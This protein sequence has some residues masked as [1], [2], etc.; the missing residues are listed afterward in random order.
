MAL[1]IQGG[2]YIGLAYGDV[3]FLDITS[4]ISQLSTLVR[5]T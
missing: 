1:N 2:I 5:G 4:L 3:P